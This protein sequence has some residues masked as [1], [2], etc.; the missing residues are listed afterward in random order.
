[1]WQQ[2]IEFWSFRD[3]NVNWVLSGCVLLGASGGIIGCFAFL[4]KRSLVGDALAHAALPGVTTAFLLTESRSPLII[5]GGAMISC[6]LGF[7]AI[8]YLT[9]NTK[10]KPDSAL[11]I[12]LSLFFALGIFQ[13][14]KIQKLP[15]ASQAGLD[16]LLFGQAASLVR[17]DVI[18]LGA[19]AISNIL[20]ISL[21]FRKLKLTTFDRHFAR[22]I[23]VSLIAYD[24]ITALLLVL[25]IVIGLQLVGV[26]LM[27][28]VLVTPAA[29]SR[30]WTDDLRTMVIISGLIGAV[31]AIVGVN[32]SYLAP[33]MPTGPWMIVSVSLIFLISVLFAPRRGVIFRIVRQQ[34]VRSKV[35]D[36]NVLRTFYKEGELL[37]NSF[38]VLEPS[39]VLKFRDMSEQQLQKSFRRL[40]RAGL[41]VSEK[42]G[43]RLTPAGFERGRHLTR[44]HRLWELYLTE[45]IDIAPDHV[46][47]DAE[48]VEHILTAELAARLDEELRAPVIDPHGKTI[49]VVTKE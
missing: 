33:R 26:V 9:K 25:S 41:L 27:A 12:V 19:I 7:L 17:G 38:T 49:P 1:M 4:R 14:T 20:V 36:E 45:R 31:S 47:A 30:Y 28:A 37:G 6:A 48:E 29:A 39:T 44:L 42:S 3:P 13:L 34:Q 32:V 46:H 11:A 2:F 40:M 43:Y 23:G 22:S 5:L 18:L 16:K 8:E 21:L 15:L 35:H 10:I 24:F